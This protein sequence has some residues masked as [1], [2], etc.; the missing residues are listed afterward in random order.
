MVAQPPAVKQCT[1]QELEIV[2]L[3]TKTP[4]C[5]HLPGL[6]LPGLLLLLLQARLAVVD[7]GDEHQAQGRQGAAGRAH[8]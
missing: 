1:Q 6:L 5:L 8:R 4:F 7:E 2:T 3:L